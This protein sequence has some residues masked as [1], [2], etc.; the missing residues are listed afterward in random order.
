MSATAEAPFAPG[1]SDGCGEVL[2]PLGRFYRFRF[3][4]SSARPIV[5]VRKEDEM[6]FRYRVTCVIAALVLSA[7]AAAAQ[8]ERLSDKAVKELIDSVDTGRDKFEGNLDGRFKGSTLRGPNGE[9]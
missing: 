6:K 2:A 8:G 5:D 1:I 3:G 7:A 4:T 9:R